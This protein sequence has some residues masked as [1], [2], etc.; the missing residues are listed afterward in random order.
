MSPCDMPFTIVTLPDER[1]LVVK[2][3]DILRQDETWCLPEYR[4]RLAVLRLASVIE[5]QLQEGPW[6]ALVLAMLV[7]PRLVEGGRDA[8]DRAK[9]CRI[10]HAGARP[11]APS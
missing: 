5:D 9:S 3:D 4:A 7:L 1:H 8:G 10:N 11:S 2:H 6:T